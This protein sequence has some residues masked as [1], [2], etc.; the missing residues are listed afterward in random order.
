M[1][2]FKSFLESMQDFAKKKKRNISFTLELHKKAENFGVGKIEVDMMG[3]P[4][5]FAYSDY[6]DYKHFIEDLT[7]DFEGNL[8]LLFKFT[9]GDISEV[10]IGCW[11]HFITFEEESIK[12]TSSSIS[13]ILFE[14]TPCGYTTGIE[15]EEC[16]SIE[17][18]ESERAEK[19]LK[20]LRRDFR[21]LYYTEA[22]NEIK[23]DALRTSKDYSLS[24]KRGEEGD[25]S[26]AI[27]LTEEGFIYKAIRPMDDEKLMNEASATIIAVFNDKSLDV[28]P[29]N[30]SSTSYRCTLKEGDSFDIYPL[31]KK[32]Y[33]YKGYTENFSEL[34]R[35]ECE[36]YISLSKGFV[37]NLMVYN[38]EE[39]EDK[40]IV[41]FNKDGEVNFT[42]KVPTLFNLELDVL[43]T[44][45]VYDA[46]N[47]LIKDIIR[48]VCFED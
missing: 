18:K 35:R 16:K 20:A 19:I 33:N 23:K 1:D 37:D 14:I 32:Y 28:S 9:S 6:L 11:D 27:S 5:T 43:H 3:R 36:L 7:Q 10:D 46:T 29:L 48:G 31:L 26:T 8:T 22:F 21:N 2:N 41:G 47:S 30:G 34:F 38:G 44:N 39:S 17:D 42:L 24:F 12:R 45:S 4:E 13:K 15:I 40:L 25:V